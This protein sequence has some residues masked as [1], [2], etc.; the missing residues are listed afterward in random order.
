MTRLSSTCPR[1]GSWAKIAQETGPVQAVPA[2]PEDEDPDNTKNEIPVHNGASC[3]PPR[4]IG[5]STASARFRQN[6]PHRGRWR[7]AANIASPI[8]GV[9]AKILCTATRSKCMLVM[10]L[11]QLD[12]RLAKSA[13][14]QAD[15]GLNQAQASLAEGA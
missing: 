11:I 7:G 12:D 8:A 4:C 10:R 1:M 9:V 5:T 13:V 2:V 6:L 3:K 15:A 14:E